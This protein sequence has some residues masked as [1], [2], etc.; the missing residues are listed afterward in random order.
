MAIR[1]RKKTSNEESMAELKAIAAAPSVD[2][3]RLL[4]YHARGVAAALEAIHGGRW[5]WS[6]NHETCFALIVRE[7]EGWNPHQD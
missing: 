6:V 3:M 2:W 4:D 5:N 7:N 1:V